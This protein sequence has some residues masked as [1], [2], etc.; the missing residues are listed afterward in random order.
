MKYGLIGERLGHSFSKMIHT[1][2]GDYDY[3]LREIPKEEL[4]GFM[5]EGDFLGINVTI[6]YKEAIIPYLDE[7]DEE[8]R[9]IG[10]VNTVVNRGGRL[11]GY[12]TD[13]YGMKALFT[14]A[15]VEAR[16]KKAAILGTGGTSKTAA[17][18]LESLGASEILRVSRGVRDGSI[19]YGELYESHTNT[20]IIVNTTPVGMYPNIDGCAVDVSQFPALSGVIDAV[21]NPI[22][23]GLVMSAMEQGIPAEGGLYML[24]A[25]AIRASEIFLNKEYHPETLNDIYDKI[26][27]EKESIVLIGMPASGKSTVGYMIAERLGRKFV[28]T[29]E[30]ITDRIKIPIKDFFTL[31]GEEKFRGIESDVI[32]K[33]AGEASL[34]IATGGGAVLREENLSALKYNGKIYFIDRP[35]EKL[36]PTDTRPLASDKASIEARYNERYALYCEGCDVHI[37]ADFDAE[38]VADKILENF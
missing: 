23:T 5:R 12:N 24:V 21:Y 4:D 13:F 6:P 34:V 22:R 18:V 27:R 31:Y 2:L 7:I 33:L 14:H 37:D 26:R 9:K 30:M 19:T 16:G 20:E 28:D 17:A 11:Y 36:I 8:A 29:D 32:R 38:S 25:Q 35:L 10:A 15:G 3:E 1:K